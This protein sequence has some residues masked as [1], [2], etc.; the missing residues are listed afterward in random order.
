MSDRAEQNRAQAIRWFREVWNERTGD[1]I[2]EIMTP[3]CKGCME[4]VGDV[5]AAGFRAA[6]S[7][8]LEAFPDLSVEVLDTVADRD[9]VVVGWR[10]SATHTGDGLGISPTGRHVNVR[11]M[12]WFT[13]ADGR[14]VEGWDSWNQG[15]LVAE[16]TGV[17]AN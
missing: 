6:W 11:G 7:S 14:I 10:L 3:D 17:A 5:D 4:G 9:H 15:A 12:T 1:A 2:E 16:L 13:F 8:M